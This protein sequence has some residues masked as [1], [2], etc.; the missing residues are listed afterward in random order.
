[1][2]S[3]RSDRDSSATGLPLDMAAVVRTAGTLEPL[4]ASVSRL[5]ALVAEEDSNLREIISGKCWINITYMV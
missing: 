2:L 3:P 5:A 4:P 1:M